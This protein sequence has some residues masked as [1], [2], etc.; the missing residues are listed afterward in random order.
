MV[1][2]I[3]IKLQ[4]WLKP[5]RF[6]VAFGG[7]GGYKTMSLSKIL[8]FLARKKKL[9]VLGI[10]EYMKSIKQSVHSSL[11]HEVETLNMSDFFTVQDSRIKG[12][13][14]SLFVYD[15]ISR[16]PS[17]IKSYDDFDIFWGEEAESFSDRS[18]KILIP[19]LR[20][21]NSELWLSFNPDNEFGAVYCRFVK[22]YLK[23]IESNGFYEDDKLLVVK[24][25]LEDNPFAPAEL[26][27]ES[28]AMKKNNYKEWLHVFCGETYGDYTNS[29]IQPEWFDAAIDAHEKLN[30]KPIG[31]KVLGFDL[32]D[33]GDDKALSA[34]E[35][36]VVTHTKRWSYGELPEAIDIAVEKAGKWGSRQ[37]VYDDDG[38]GKSMKVYLDKV[39][40]NDKL[41]VIPYNGNAKVERPEEF[42]MNN[43]KNKDSFRNKRA[44]TY[45]QLADRFEATFNAINSGIYTD[46]DNLIS[47]CSTIEDLDVLKSELIKIKELTRNNTRRQLEPKKNINDSPNMADSLNMCFANPPINVLKYE[48]LEFTSEF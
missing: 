48:E 34:R 4:K 30:F 46:P 18:L 27:D 44:Q 36:V 1:I 42:H 26:I 28:A 22:P 16:N 31:A 41:D 23:K 14:N 5:K 47:I 29:I 40:I 15:G 20:K 25:S 45:I 17:A 32:A 6:K 43:R 11:S 9:K 13:N 39:L 12:K 8:L 35:G 24:T 33:T 3:P 19:T 2:Q 21:D 38:L 10:R 37:I 7:R